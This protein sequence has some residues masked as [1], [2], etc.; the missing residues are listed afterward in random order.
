VLNSPPAEG[1]KGGSGF[2]TREILSERLPAP[3]PETLILSCGPP[4]MVDAM[5]AHLEGLGYAA[6]MQHQF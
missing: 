5:K 1:W 4:P 6:D 2:I 3:G